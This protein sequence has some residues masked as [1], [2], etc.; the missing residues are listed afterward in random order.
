M[1]TFTVTTASDAGADGTLAGTAEA[2]AA[3]G[4]GLSLRE[5]LGWASGAPAPVA[6]AFAHG[7]GDAFDGGGRVV[8]EHGQLEVLGEVVIDGDADGDGT[9]DVTIDG[10]GGSRVFRV[11]ADAE[12]RGLVVTGGDV[13]GD[14][15]GIHVEAGAT[16]RFEDGVVTGNLASV[17]GGGIHSDGT[18]HIARSVV[19]D[20]TAGDDGGGIRSAGALVMIDSAV[21]GNRG[22]FLGGGLQIWQGTATLTRVT[23]S[24]N[25]AEH[26]GG[27]RNDASATLTDVTLDRNSSF[28]NGGGIDN[29]GVLT[30]AGGIIRDN[31]ASQTG[32]GIY[33]ND[34]GRATLDGVGIHRNIADDGGGVSIHEDGAV[35]LR[36]VTL[37]RNVASV[38][39]GGMAN[40]GEATLAS[41]TIVGNVAGDDGGGIENDGEMTLSNV[42]IV[43]N[44]AEDEGGGILNDGA[45][46]LSNVTVTGNFAGDEG[47][48]IYVD[49]VGTISAPNTL[50][51]GNAAATGPDLRGQVAPGGP[52]SLIGG[53]AATVAAVFAAV[54]PLTGGGTLADNGG[55]VAT[56]AL[57]DDPSNP[58][59]DVGDDAAAPAQDARGVARPQ[60]PHADIG[61][62]ELVVDALPVAADDAVATDARTPISG[63]VLADNGAG[64][65]ADPEGG[66]LRLAAVN[67]SVGAVGAQITLA[68]GA[69]LR[70][71]PDGTFD[72]DPAGAHDRLA[73]GEG[74]LE[75]VGYTLADGAGGTDA[76]TLTIAVGGVDDAPVAADDAASI[77]RGDVFRAAAAT[78]VLANDLDAEG[79][80]LAVIAVDGDA[81]KLGRPVAGTYGDLVLAADGAWSYAPRAAATAD[82]G[83]GEMR[84]DVF[85]YTVSDGAGGRGTA[86]LAVDVFG[87]PD[88]VMRLLAP[89][90]LSVAEGGRLSFSL[91]VDHL[92]PG[93]VS[94]HLGGPTGGDLR[95]PRSAGS[96]EFVEAGPGGMLSGPW[97]DAVADGLLEAAETFALVLTVEGA[98]FAGGRS[99]RQVTVEVTDVPFRAGPEGASVRGTVDADTILGGVGADR[100]RGLQGDDLLEGA[101]G[102]D[103]LRGGAGRDTLRGGD[104]DDA[105]WGGA[106]ADDLRGGVGADRLSGRRGDDTLIGGGGDDALRGET[107]R[108]TLRGGGGDDMLW[109]GAGADDLRGGVGVDR[110]SGRRGDDVLDGGRGRDVLRGGEGRDTLRGGGGDD[111]LYGGEGADVFVYDGGRDRVRDFR[112]GDDTLRLDPSLWDGASEV[113]AFLDRHGSLRGEDAVL[114]WGDGNV[115]VIEDLGRLPTEQEIGFV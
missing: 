25:V 26:G 49:D 56:V 41:V 29:D 88:P 80:A 111:E 1:S 4:G 11:A 39:G 96:M 102:D 103:E 20:N 16:L 60:G 69:L 14:G 73:A 32:G 42:T 78:G 3:D 65:D 90:G 110:L 106:G 70:L 34:E 5:A 107:G 21:T 74:A 108:D 31:A 7:P 109:G 94:W 33:Q 113:D 101:A 104:G 57:R 87:R 62:Y 68:S 47:G 36:Q 66:A 55:P 63:D 18:A 27:L 100:L 72:Y 9:P 95:I 58:A 19:S 6:I 52:P 13:S 54:D 24:G 85:S 76:G 79:G 59:L 53:D 43:D 98:T 64:P 30:M 83:L 45:A 38:D 99:S 8:L 10:G 86:A 67:G 15:G 114:A 17:D 23:I 2:D 82:L 48:G 115:L 77:T 81:A 105:L 93:P 84:R 50:V 12:M 28:Q 75:V 46:T 51:L 92:P 61:A 89:E 112:P 40:F 44:V 91:A 71:R 37:A 35:D 97:V 22:D